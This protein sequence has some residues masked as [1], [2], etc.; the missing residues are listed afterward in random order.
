M[1]G[2]FSGGQGGGR[3][4]RKNSKFNNLKYLAGEHGGKLHGWARWRE[5]GNEVDARSTA[6]VERLDGK[7]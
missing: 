4:K 5:G 1:E 7:S 6:Q 2:S 3:E